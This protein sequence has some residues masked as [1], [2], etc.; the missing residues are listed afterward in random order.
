MT[1]HFDLFEVDKV[2]PP[3]LLLT[4]IVYYSNYLG[5]INSI[6]LLLLYLLSPP[7]FAWKQFILT[8]MLVLSI[9]KLVF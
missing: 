8:L 5:K 4:G 2:G 7:F 3:S 9:L 6:M 1:L